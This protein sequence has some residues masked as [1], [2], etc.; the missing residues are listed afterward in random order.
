[1]ISTALSVKRY[2]EDLGIILNQFLG[3]CIAEM[4]FLVRQLSTSR[5]WLKAL[6]VLI[7]N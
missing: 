5:Q 4:T 2:N 7:R 6:A 3:A 1:M